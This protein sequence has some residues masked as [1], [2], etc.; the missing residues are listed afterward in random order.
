MAGRGD[1]NKR[2]SA[3]RGNSNQSN[4][5]F[6]GDGQKQPK[7]N[8]GKEHTGGKP[9]QPSPRT[10]EVT[11]NRNQALKNGKQKSLSSWKKAGERGSRS[12]R[13]GV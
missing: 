7:S 1:N 13:P 12:N 2:G 10:A 6:A 9:S 11:A 4:Q 8:H 5:P 3:G